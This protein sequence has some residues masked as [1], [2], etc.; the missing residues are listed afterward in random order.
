MSQSK[1][2]LFVCTPEAVVKNSFKALG[3]SVQVI[4]Y[5]PH[6]LCSWYVFYL[7]FMDEI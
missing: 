5:F 1:P 3:T 7:L 6:R 4:P 2:S